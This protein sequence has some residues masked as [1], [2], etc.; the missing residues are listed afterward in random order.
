MREYKVKVN[1]SDCED[2]VIF[3]DAEDLADLKEKI[4]L[5]IIE[6]DYDGHTMFLQASQITSVEVL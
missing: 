4:F 3:M 6:F 2:Y 5:G 1:M